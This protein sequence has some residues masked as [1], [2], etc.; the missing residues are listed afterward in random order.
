[1]DQHQIDCINGDIGDLRAN[2][3]NLRG[4]VEDLAQVAANLQ[5][6]RLRTILSLLDYS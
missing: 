5:G 3:S 4:C 1:M 6:A 2:V